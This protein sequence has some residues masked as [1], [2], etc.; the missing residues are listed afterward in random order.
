MSARYQDPVIGRF[1]QPDTIV[2]EPGDPQSWN[3]YSYVRNNPVNRID[4]TGHADLEADPK[5]RDPLPEILI[6]PSQGPFGNGCIDCNIKNNHPL[7]K[8]EPIDL[9]AARRIAREELAKRP[10]G[11]NDA[12]DAMRHAEWM[13][14]TAEEVN[15]TTAKVA[16]YGHEVEGLLAGQPIREAVMDLHNNR[17]GRAA[18]VAKKPVDPSKLITS[19]TEAFGDY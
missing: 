6:D 5:S 2:P 3:R 17:E 14:R 7:P 11:H 4:P 10:R 1:A 13:R 12:E 8:Y 16:G 9:E 18:G 15:E 19:P